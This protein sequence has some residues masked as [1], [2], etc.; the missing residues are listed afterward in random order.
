M[1]ECGN[2]KILYYVYK[3]EKLPRSTPPLDR[4]K[5]TTPAADK[6]RQTKSTIRYRN[7]QNSKVMMK[8][9]YF[10]VRY[11][12]LVVNATGAPRKREVTRFAPKVYPTINAAAEAC[13][14]AM[15]SRPGKSFFVQ[16]FERELNIDAM[17]ESH[18]FKEGE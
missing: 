18:G 7:Q 2:E 6:D 5:E 10:G 14:Q 4:P 16:G 13:A 8:Y 15:I 12:E 17:G 11:Q 9:F 1:C 3:N